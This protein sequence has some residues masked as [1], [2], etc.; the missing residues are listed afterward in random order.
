MEW[1][2]YVQ[3]IFKWRYVLD[4]ILLM[5]YPIL[6]TNI[7]TSNKNHR[8]IVSEL[9]GNVSIVYTYTWLMKYIVVFIIMVWLTYL[10]HDLTI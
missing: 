8:E 4:G 2:G 9:Y 3:N 1:T 5:S 7:W 6:Q 10:K